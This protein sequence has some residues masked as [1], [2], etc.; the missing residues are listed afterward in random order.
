MVLCD[1]EDA[2]TIDYKR[3]TLKNHLTSTRGHGVADLLQSAL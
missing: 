3:L 2:P 1:T